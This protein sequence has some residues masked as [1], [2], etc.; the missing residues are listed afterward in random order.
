MAD[1]LTKVGSFEFFNIEPN[2]TKDISSDY[3]LSRRLISYS[4][5]PAI[6]E[7]IAPEVP[8]VL[9]MEFLFEDKEAEYNMITFF[10]SKRGR[11]N[12]FWL[13]S[14]TEAFTLR[15]AAISGATG[16]YCKRNRFDLVYQGYERIYIMMNNNDIVVRKIT[17]VVDGEDLTYIGFDTVLD[18]DIT[19]T[20][21]CKIGRLLLCRFNDDKLRFRFRT[22]SVSTLTIGFLELVKE[23]SLAD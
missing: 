1:S 2:W 3:L 11:L 7:G 9:Q 10:V 23:Y 12:R 19:L 16:L 22:S 15:T 17:S 5:T 14:P 6:F 4:G 8:V 18:R 20:N 21:H 13:R